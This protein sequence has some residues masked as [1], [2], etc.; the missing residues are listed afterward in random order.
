MITIDTQ[1]NTEHTDIRM[2][3][4]LERGVT[5]SVELNYEQAEDMIF[6]LQNCLQEIDIN[7]I[8]K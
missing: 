3:I 7:E 2:S 5:L 4:N 6:T 1:T 8:I